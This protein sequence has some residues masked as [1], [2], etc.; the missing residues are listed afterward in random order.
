MSVVRRPTSLPPDAASRLVN[1]DTTR[2]EV[3]FL[4]KVTFT[5]SRRG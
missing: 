3:G 4:S 2:F 5:H 1:G